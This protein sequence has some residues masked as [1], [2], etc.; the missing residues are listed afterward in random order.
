MIHNAKTD[1]AYQLLN[2]YASIQD[3]RNQVWEVYQEV[4]AGNDNE[5][6]V[7]I[8]ILG[9]ILDGLR[10]G[11]WLWNVPPNAR[12]ITTQESFADFV[13]AGGNPT[14]YKGET[15]SPAEW[16]EVK[17]RQT[18]REGQPRHWRTRQSRGT[19]DMSKKQW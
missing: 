5:D 3:H 12:T 19:G 7:I 6:Q 11:N 15:P 9:Y 13:L 18:E 1:K 4:L 17:R 2:S 16:A 8:T 10:F 14:E